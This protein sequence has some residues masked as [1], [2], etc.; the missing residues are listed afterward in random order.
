[1]I[2]ATSTLILLGALAA[3][4]TNAPKIPVNPNPKE[5]EIGC[6]WKEQKKCNDNGGVVLIRAGDCTC[7]VFPP[8]EG[9]TKKEPGRRGEPDDD[10]EPKATKAPT[11][12]L[13]PATGLT[14]CCIS[15]KYNCY[16]SHYDCD[17]CDEKWKGWREAVKEISGSGR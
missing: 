10:E 2:F 14:K 1:M 5:M 7:V 4:T 6:S 15:S 3:P 17:V 9:E 8:K 16:C 12:T 11:R 13:R